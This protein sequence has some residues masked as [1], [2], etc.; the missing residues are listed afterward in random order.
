M[1]STKV[2]VDQNI[3][4]AKVQREMNRQLEELRRK[5][6]EE[7]NT[8]RE[9]N[10]RM[11]A[12]IEQNP[13]QREESRSNE[14]GGDGTGRDES[15]IQTTTNQTEEARAARRHPFVDGIMEVELPAR[16]KGLTIS[17]YDG[18]TDLE[19]HVDV[20]T[21][22]AGLYTSNDAILCRVFPTSLKG[23][24]LNWFTR[25]PPNSV[26]CFDTLATRF[27]IQFATSKPD[28]LLWHW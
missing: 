9:E 14:E 10:Q 25:L 27:G 5:N 4:A 17:Q 23:P 18:T 28:H 12:Q 2:A 26:D 16:W 6:E 8:L 19:E 7:L 24:A 15:R 13:I 11:R 21:T 1:V 22:Q 20:F 3:V